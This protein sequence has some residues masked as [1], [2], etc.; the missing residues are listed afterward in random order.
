MEQIVLDEQLMRRYL[1]GQLSEKKREQIEERL[2]TDDEFFESVIDLEDSVED[3]LIEQYIS[4]EL[5]GREKQSFEQVFLTTPERREK[6]RLAQDLDTYASRMTLGAQVSSK[7]D[8]RLSLWRS[9][10]DA[11]RFQ[12]PGAALLLTAALVLML[13]GSAWLA[14]KVRHLE[15]ELRQTRDQQLDRNRELTTSLQQSEEQ[16]AKLEQELASLKAQQPLI[17][18]QPD[19]IEGVKPGKQIVSI[20]LPMLPSRGADGGG[21]EVLRMPPNARSFK[22]IL[23]LDNIDLRDYKSYKVVL[24]K[25]DGT[26]ILETGKVNLLTGHGQ[27]NISVTLPARLF[28]GGEYY[29]ELNGVPNSG[30]HEPIGAYSFR[31]VD[32]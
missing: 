19:N 25:R 16:R 13:I 20:F 31:I 17:P 4:G 28:P 24:E 12:N 29:V 22:L 26:R 23:S 14:L 1:L 8:T 27:Y 2:M 3:E 15:G 9:L 10:S 21:T 18:E 7:P 11:L 5:A 30:D 32:R 6:L